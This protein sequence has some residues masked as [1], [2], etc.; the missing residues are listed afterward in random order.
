MLLKLAKLFLYVSLFSVIIVL[1]ST[2]FPFI[3]GKYY[4]FRV[5]V[6]LALIF[7]LLGWAFQ[8]SPGEVKKRVQKISRQPLFI[9][10]S[11]FA[12]VYLL[13]SLF[14]FDPQA[15]FWSNYERGEGGFQMVHYYIFFALLVTLFKEKK[16]WQWAF[17]LSLIAALLMIGYGVFANLEVGKFIS[18]YR[19]TAPEG[20]WAKL[21]STRFQGSLGNPAYVA[22][23]LMFSMFFAL[24]LWFEKAWKNK[25]VQGLIYGGLS[26]IFLFFFALSRTRGAFLGLAAA[27]L[28]FLIYLI[29]KSAKIRKWA[30]IAL[31]SFTVLV[32][33]AWYYHQTPFIQSLPGSRIFEIN[34]SNRDVQTRFWTW[35][36][37]LKGF[38]ERPVFGWGPENFSAVFDKHF[39]PRHYIPGN[40][41]AETWFDRAHSI[42]FD[43]LT[44][45]GILGFLSF[46][47]IFGVFFWLFFKKTR[48][49]ANNRLIN[50]NN[51]QSAVLNGLLLAAPV[52]YLVQ[53]SFLFDVLPIYLPLFVLLA[54]GSWWF[55]KEYEP[56]Y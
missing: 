46:F 11:A 1:P 8:A 41:S 37:A 55:S 19:G 31:A 15:A 36:S 38:L 12:L 32:G 7:F 43:Y 30:A 28:V 29:L 21:I 25:I 6:E 42:I 14:A 2:F 39:D 3:G 24:Y 34:L 17:R 27:I 48:I 56:E 26:A 53:G 18:P 40:E 51:N 9:A 50:T 54:F 23:Y 5:S 45:T 4:F 20:A 13:A 10:V 52:G 44:E 22:P 49:D 33:I 35:N 47:G 16:D